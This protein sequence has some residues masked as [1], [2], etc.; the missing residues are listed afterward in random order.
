VQHPFALDDD[1]F[2]DV[3][4]GARR[5]EERAI[6]LLFVDLQPRLLR[7]LRGAEPRVADDLAA[8]VW[9]ALA[10]GMRS[11]EGDLDGFRAWAFTIARRRLIDHRRSATRRR[12]EPTGALELVEAPLATDP[13]EHVVDRQ[14]AQEAIDLIA[15]ELPA[16]LAEVLLL[17]VVGGL[18]VAHVAAVMGRTAN[19]VRV[20]QHRALRRLASRFPTP[21]TDSST[22]GSTDSSTFLAPAVIPAPSQAISTS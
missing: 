11:F 22:E 1:S 3:I 20:M 18:D 14:S 17:R 13:A 15:R 6:Q 12:T 2:V 7:F 9:L 19:W 4:A 8:E 10:K 21:T 16:D 5:G